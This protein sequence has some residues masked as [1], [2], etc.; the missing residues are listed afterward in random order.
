MHY[1]PAGD[2]LRNNDQLTCKCQ[3]PGSA[4]KDNIT[5]ACQVLKK[6]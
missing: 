6:L 1:D 3:K 4:E 2:S 5:A